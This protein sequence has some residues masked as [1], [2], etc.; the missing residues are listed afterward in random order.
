[1]VRERYFYLVANMANAVYEMGLSGN[2]QAAKYF[3]NTTDP[4]NWKDKREIDLNDKTPRKVTDEDLRN[5]SDEELEQIAN[6]D[7]VVM[8]NG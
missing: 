4:G 6:S 7:N 3:L 2:I 1:M 8:M 5:M